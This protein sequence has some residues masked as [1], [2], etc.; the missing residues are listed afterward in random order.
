MSGS[1][2]Y[3]NESRCT[4]LGDARVEPPRPNSVPSLTRSPNTSFSSACSPVKRGRST[5]TRASSSAYS[6]AFGR[7]TMTPALKYSSSRSEAQKRGPHSNNWSIGRRTST[8]ESRYTT[9]SSSS[10]SAHTASFE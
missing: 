4:P 8:S 5:A 2:L 1:A 7:S 3:V 10:C 9:R 6:V